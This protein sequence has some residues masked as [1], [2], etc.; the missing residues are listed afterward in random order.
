MKQ[1]SK[2]QFENFIANASSLSETETERDG[3]YAYENTLNREGETIAF[4]T[5]RDGEAISYH[6]AD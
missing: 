5:Y 3:E 2:E 1:V 6:I 4:V